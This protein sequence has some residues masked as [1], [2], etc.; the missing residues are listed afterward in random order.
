MTVKLKVYDLNGDRRDARSPAPRSTCGTATARARYSLYSDGVTDENYL[1]GVQEAD[2][3]GAR[4]FTTIFPA[5]YA[6]RWPHMHFEVYESLDRATS[7]HQQ[8]AHLPARAPR[9]R[10]PT[11]STATSTATSQRQQPRRGVSLDTDSV[12]SDGYSLQLATRHR[13]G[14]RGLHVHASTS[15]SEPGDWSGA[16][17]PARRRAGAERR[18]PAGGGA[19][20]RWGSGR[21]GSTCTCRSARCAAATATSTP[22]P[23]PSSA[24]RP[25]CRAPRGRRT[26]RRRSRRSGWPG[27]C[28][29]TRDLPVET[30]FFGGGTPTL[31]SPA[32]LGVG[33]GARSTPSSGW[34]RTPRSPPR[35]TRTASRKADLVALRE[36]GFNRISFG[37]QSA[38]DHVLA[39]P[40]PHPRP[41]R[42]CRTSS[43]WARAAGFEQVSLDLIYGTPGESL[44]DWEASLDAALACAPDHVSAYSLIVEDGTALARRVRRGELPMPD[45]DDLADKYPL[46][47]ER[48]GAAG[49]G[50]YE[51]SNWARDEA[52]RCRHNLLYWTGGGLVGRRPGR[53]LARRR[54]AVVERQAPRGVRRAARRR[55]QPG[56]RPRGARRRDP[57]GRAGAAR[58]PAARRAAARRARRRRPGGGRRAGRATGWSTVEGDRLV[59]T[60]RGRLLADARGPRPAALSRP[61]A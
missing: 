48:L 11:R 8:A 42:G 36:A 58:G 50:W 28:S 51:V 35:P 39:R 17:R 40:R 46:A 43:A 4:E 34:R 3:D 41:A 19:G 16:V 31:L 24:R 59:L 53:A 14:R 52:A 7:V 44:A 12:F 26:P 25:A 18:Q 33:A 61:R 54:R 45:E 22:T 27:G 13:L 47:D 2:A 10:L 32:D 21:S 1:R 5:C 38:V 56:A 55:A 9:G 37:M 57:A 23:P 6:G 60:P 49:L 29:A 20:R 15:R 30:V